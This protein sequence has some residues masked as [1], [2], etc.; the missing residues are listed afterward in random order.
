MHNIYEMIYMQVL[1]KKH[2]MKLERLVCELYFLY[3]CKAN[4]SAHDAH[5]LP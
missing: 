2:N 4:N 3:E 1:G 5:E